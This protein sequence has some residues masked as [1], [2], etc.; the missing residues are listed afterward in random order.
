MKKK[1]RI[2]MVSLSMG[3]ADSTATIRTFKPLILE[4]V[5]KG[6]STLKVLREETEIPTFSS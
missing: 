2:I 5:F 6:L 1:I 3:K 4:M